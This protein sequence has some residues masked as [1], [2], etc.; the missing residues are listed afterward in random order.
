MKRDTVKKD[1]E[2]FTL[3]RSLLTIAVIL[4][5]VAVFYTALAAA[6]RQNG[7]LGRR[8]GEELSFRREKIMERLR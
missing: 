6:V 8:L 3:L 1:N 4:L 5:C 7:H 2:G